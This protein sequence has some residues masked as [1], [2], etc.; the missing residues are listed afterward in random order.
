LWSLAVGSLVVQ[1]EA[2]GAAGKVA[3]GVSLLEAPQRAVNVPRLQR[4][5]ILTEDLLTAREEVLHSLGY[6][7]TL[8]YTRPR[9]L[10]P[11]CPDGG[12]RLTR[13]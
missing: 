6:G 8:S 3:A 10:H 11:M 2:V 13:A 9:P 12:A 4:P 5:A 7:Q 1:S